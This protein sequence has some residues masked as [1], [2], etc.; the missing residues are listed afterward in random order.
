[1][2]RRAGETKILRIVDQL[3]QSRQIARWRENTGENSL[4]VHVDRVRKVDAGAR[5]TFFSGRQFVENATESVD[6][7]LFQRLKREISFDEFSSRSNVYANRFRGENVPAVLRR[8]AR[9]RVGHVQ[10]TDR[11]GEL[12]IEENVSRVKM[13]VGETVAVDKIQSV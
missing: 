2:D 9:D 5:R 13:S 1:M 8:N 7:A 11:L 4:H 6:I 3:S 12:R 10:Q